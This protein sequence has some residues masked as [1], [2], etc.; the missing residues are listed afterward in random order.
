VVICRR[1]RD[2]VSKLEQEKEEEK[3]RWLRKRDAKLGNKLTGR[4]WRDD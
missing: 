4:R 3:V 2:E 1:Q